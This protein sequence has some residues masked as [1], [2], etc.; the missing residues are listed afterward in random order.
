MV[1]RKKEIKIINKRRRQIERKLDLVDY[2]LKDIFS[3]G[4][5]K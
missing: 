3:P 5:K 1:E 4:V 2:D